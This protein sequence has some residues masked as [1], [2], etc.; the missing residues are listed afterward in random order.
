MEDNATH[1]AGE[2]LKDLELALDHLKICVLPC[3]CLGLDG[4]VPRL[5]S[6]SLERALKTIDAETTEWAD[7]Q[8]LEY[9]GVDSV[10]GLLRRIGRTEAPD[11]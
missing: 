9:Q 6:Q 7:E 11:S 3:G 5:L 8:E 10:R 2:S 1:V 4:T